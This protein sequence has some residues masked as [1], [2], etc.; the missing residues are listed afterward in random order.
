[1]NF[2]VYLERYVEYLNKIDPNI[3]EE[4][5]K[6]VQFIQQGKNEKRMPE[7]SSLS[8]LNFNN[9]IEQFKALL[10]SSKTESLRKTLLSKLRSLTSLLKEGQKWSITQA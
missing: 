1:M 5:I 4:V 8:F 7:Q 10:T 9:L 2:K 3:L 6:N